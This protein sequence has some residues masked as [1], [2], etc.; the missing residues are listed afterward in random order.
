MK[1]SVFV[2]FVGYIWTK[3]LLGLVIQPYRSVRDVTHHPV[4]LPV[5]FSPLYGL[6]I[7]F[8]IGR[9]GSFLFELTG[10][11][12]ELMALLLSSGLLSILMW[13]LLLLYLL[14]N[15]QIIKRR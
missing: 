11:K 13:Q 9:I 6:I 8:I 12:R 15:F 14:L 10:T 1:K 2:V 3:T 4:L 7:L 5:V